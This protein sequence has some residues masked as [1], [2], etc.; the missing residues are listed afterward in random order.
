MRGGGNPAN[1]YH[2]VHLDLLELPGPARLVAREEHAC[3]LLTR[4][5]SPDV[6]YEWSINPYRGCVHGCAYC[7]ARRT[8]EYLDLGAGSDFERLVVVKV[9]A[10][11]LLR[12]E[13]RRRGWRR[14]QI[15][16]SGVTDCY[17]PL[18]TRYRLTRQCLEACLEVANPV[19][20]VTKS[21]LIL[22]DKDLLAELDR[23]SSVSI[24]FSIAFADDRLARR[25]ESNAP[26]PG[27]RF[28]AMRR[29]R[30]AGLSV[31]VMVAPVIPGL[32]DRDIPALLE[33]AAA[34]GATTAHYAPLRLPGSVAEVFLGRLQREMP[35][36][37]RRVEAR[38]REM[39]GG[40]LNDSRFGRRM[41]A[42]GQY[43]GS[44]ERLFHVVATRVG[45]DAGQRWRKCGRT[46]AVAAPKQLPLF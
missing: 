42:S 22:R 36:L 11:E 23:R 3:S 27:Q 28:E 6:P 10:P 33:R 19:G 4:N 25:I 38:L 24:L 21:P 30:A 14:E 35:A 15:A 40:R 31:G 17:Q 44:V 39:R 5:T 41:T 43:W 12:A 2:P 8:H 29:L 16:L 9:N 26:P 32:N 1:P 13:L 46:E 37:A 34:C 20:I 7:Y 45:L 18:E